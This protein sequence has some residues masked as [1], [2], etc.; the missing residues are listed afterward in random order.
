MVF[1]RDAEMTNHWIDDQLF[2]I[3]LDSSDVRG[4]VSPGLCTRP[5]AYRCTALPVNAE[6]RAA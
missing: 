1:C 5:A 3:L 2:E 4:T 6:Q